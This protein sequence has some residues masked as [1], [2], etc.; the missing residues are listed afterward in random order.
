[1]ETRGE[2]IPGEM[3]LTLGL[4]VLLLRTENSLWW[5]EELGM[6]QEVLRC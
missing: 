5:L 3:L 6:M 4:L 2:E 1:M